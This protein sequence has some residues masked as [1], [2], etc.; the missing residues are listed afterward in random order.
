[1]FD[2]S[3]F[4]VNLDFHWTSIWRGSQAANHPFQ[5]SH[6][7]SPALV[8]RTGSPSIIEKSGGVG[9]FCFL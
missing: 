4:P 5:L 7:F 8:S 6:V 1:M 9:V 2:R 3:Q